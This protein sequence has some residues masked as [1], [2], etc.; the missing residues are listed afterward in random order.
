MYHI[1]VA[2]TRV[3]KEILM[4][5]ITRIMVFLRMDCKWLRAGTKSGH[6]HHITPG[7]VL[8]TGNQTDKLAPGVADP[9]EVSQVDRRGLVQESELWGLVC[10]LALL[11][12]LTRVIQLL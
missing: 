8:S 5:A 11:C 2:P 1:F 9:I 6:A 4:F 3:Y 12:H 7:E 10:I